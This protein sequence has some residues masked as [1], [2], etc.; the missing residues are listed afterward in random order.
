M[1]LAFLID[2]VQEHA[3]RV[4]QQA[5]VA[6]KARIRLWEAL[7]GRVSHRKYPDW[8]TL[9]HGLANRGTAPEELESIKPP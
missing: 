9:M 5:R 1:L 2:Q 8:A 3:C 6:W 4:F 7:R